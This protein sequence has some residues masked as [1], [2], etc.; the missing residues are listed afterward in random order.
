[1]KSSVRFLTV[2]LALAVTGCTGTPLVEPSVSDP[3]PQSPVAS[4]ESPGAPSAAPTVPVPDPDASTS[5]TPD[6]ESEEPVPEPAAGAEA[7]SALPTDLNDRGNLEENVGEESIF[8]GDS[9]EDY[10]AM[11]AEEIQTDFQCTGSGAQKSINGQFVAISFSVVAQPELAASGWP[12]LYMSARE[13][14]A[15]DADGEAVSDPVGNSA[16]C[17]DDADLLPSPVEP[18]DDLNGLIILD[19]PEGG[20]SAAFTVGGFEGSYGW[21]W[22]W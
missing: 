6:S 11:K 16:G 8:Q 2:A 21:E 7:D 17:V 12:A 19:V 9:G 22:E 4:S 13:F 5:A 14:K 1:M 18:G 15:W 20:G 10:A 3:A